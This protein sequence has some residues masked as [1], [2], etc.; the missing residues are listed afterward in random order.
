MNKAKYEQRRAKGAEKRSVFFALRCSLFVLCLGCAAGCGEAVHKVQGK[1]AF[2]GKAL[3]GGGAIVFLPLDD[4]RKPANG[5]IAADGSYQLS[6]NKP[7]DGALT[8]EYRV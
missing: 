8:G 3:P 2:E 5:D 4:T 1:V 7:G 6:T